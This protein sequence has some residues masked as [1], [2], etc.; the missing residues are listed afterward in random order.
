MRILIVNSGSSSVKLRLLS[1]DDAV[2]ESD[3]L[4][5]F[6]R[7]LHQRLTDTIR[8]YGRIDAVGHRIVHGGTVFTGPVVIDERVVAALRTL[9]GLAPLN[10]PPALAALDLVNSAIPRTPSVACFDTAFHTSLPTA[11]HTY[12]LPREWRERWDLRRYGFHGLS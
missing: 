4:P 11:A 8:R 10:Q 2:M 12:A 3:D 7:G 1:D 5:P 9:G 6:D